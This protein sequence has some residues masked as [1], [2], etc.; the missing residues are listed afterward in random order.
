MFT[1]IILFFNHGH[2]PF[3]T[4]N[5]ETSLSIYSSNSEAF[6]SELLENIESDVIAGS[7][8]QPQSGV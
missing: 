8:L 6:A 2:D 3:T 4:I 5:G 1:I 7:D